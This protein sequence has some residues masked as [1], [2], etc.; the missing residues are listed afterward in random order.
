MPSQTD[1]DQGGTN[2]AW[3]PQ[4]QGPSI[5]WIWVPQNNLLPITL[6]GTYI[7]D[8]ST[9]L[10][11]VN[12]AGAV[13]ITMPRATNPNYAG[14]GMTQPG[15]FADNPITIVDIGGN[16]FSNPITINAASGENI[17]GLSSIQITINYG[18]Y[19]LAPST[20]QQG[21]ISISP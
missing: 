4:W 13:T 2:R 1:L 18:G 7:L 20:V 3:I 9:S 16:A 17:M 8:L 11:T 15:L 5:G 19:T 14:A 10:V 21:W 12:V 6:A